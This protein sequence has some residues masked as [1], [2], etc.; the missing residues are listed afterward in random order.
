MPSDTKNITAKKSL[1]GFVN[2]MI[3]MLYGRLAR[4]IPAIKAPIAIERLR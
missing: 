4:V 1:R 2:E 3:S